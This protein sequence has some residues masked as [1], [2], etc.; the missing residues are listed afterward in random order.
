MRPRRA[1]R[2]GARGRRRRCRRRS[3]F[4]A[5]SSRPA[6]PPRSPR[7]AACGRRRARRAG[8]ARLDQRER[9][10]AV[11]RAADDLEPVPVEDLRDRGQH[12]RMVVGDDTGDGIGHALADAGRAVDSFV[13]NTVPPG[14][15][16]GRPSNASS[17]PSHARPRSATWPRTSP[18]TSRILSSACSGSSISCSKMRRPE[19]TTR[20]ACGSSPSGTRD[21]GYPRRPARLRTS[22][23][24]E[25]A[26]A[27]LAAAVQAALGL[28]RHGTASSLE[29]DE[30]Y[31]AVPQLVACPEPLLRQAVLHLLLAA[32]AGTEKSRSRCPAGRYGVAGRTRVARHARG[33]A[34]RRRPRRHGGGGDAA[35]TLRLPSL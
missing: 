30:R 10:R 29:V 6:S 34:H 11:A 5:R 7:A 14:R 4:R 3:P 13:N 16:S 31:P 24:S 15:A 12:R 22:A 18:T 25:A 17:L 32:R 35:L 8:C 33:G 23:A 21:E 1:P 19:P 28:V 2:R 27:D 26:R 9:L 20:F